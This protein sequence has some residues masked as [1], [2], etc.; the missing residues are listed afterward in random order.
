MK[1]QFIKD[2]SF[3]EKNYLLFKQQYGFRNKLS[4]NHAL[5]DI[6][7][8]I[9]KAC[10]NG[11]YACGIYVDF[12]KAFDTVNHN[13]LLGKLAH[14]GVRGI[15]NNWF[16]TYLTNRKQHVTVSDQKSDNPLIKFGFTQGSILDP[17]LFLKYIH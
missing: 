9:Q 7:N 17:L 16:K 1:R 4:T 3:L 13:I 11:Q 8:R 2:Y 10:D 12:E 14:Y 5:I 6:T 15:E